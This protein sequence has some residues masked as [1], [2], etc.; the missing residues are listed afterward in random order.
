MGA[1]SCRHRVDRL[2][3]RRE[4]GLVGLDQRVLRVD[5]VKGRYSLVRVDDDL[6]GVADVVYGVAAEG[7]L[8]RVGVARG[9][10]VG[11]H[12]PVEATVD[13]DKVRIAIERQE[14]C[15]L[16]GAVEDVAAVQHRGMAG[17]LAGHKQV[18]VAQLERPQR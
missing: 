12:D 6:D 1:K 18:E 10:R 3:H 7:L 8:L 4:G 16:P 13:D 14:G 5:H 17:H 15:N 9:G 2:E 11:V